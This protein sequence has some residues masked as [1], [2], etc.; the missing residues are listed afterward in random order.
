MSSF[1]SAEGVEPPDPYA[2]AR[3]LPTAIGVSAGTFAVL[4]LVAGW[5]WSRIAV[6]PEFMVYRSDYAYYTSEAEFTRAFDMDVAFAVIAAI[7]AVVGGLVVG[8]LFW[9]LGWS[10]TLLAAVCALGAG[11]LAWLLG[12]ELG[13][14]AVADSA[15]AA[16]RGDT[17]TGPVRL[18][19]RSILLIWP[20]LALI[21]VMVAVW[22]R[23]PR[24]EVWYGQSPMQGNPDDQ[25]GVERP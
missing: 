24:D 2:R 23:A 5:L 16:Q 15:A 10:V 9:R 12:T 13:P 17:F 18:G 1:A 11:A 20:I 7:A 6:P 8:W 14:Q 19:A 22:L 25:V 3:S 4:G 21:G